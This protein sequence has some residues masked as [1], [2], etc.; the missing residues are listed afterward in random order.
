MPIRWGWDC[1]CFLLDKLSSVLTAFL[2]KLL[3]CELKFRWRPIVTPRYLD[4]WFQGIVEQSSRSLRCGRKV[5]QQIL[6]VF[7]M[8]NWLIQL[9][10]ESS[11]LWSLIV[12]F[13]EFPLKVIN[14]VS[15]M[16]RATFAWLVTRMSLMY[17]LY[18]NGDSRERIAAIFRFDNKIFSY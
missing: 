7:L 5:R 8:C 16:N 4:S 9:E 1:S 17:T 11:C 14:I 2:T 13:F 12:T 6:P 18:R 15:S 10:V 3:M